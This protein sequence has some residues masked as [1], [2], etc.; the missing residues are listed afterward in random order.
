MAG[1]TSNL[2]LNII[3][4]SD[5]VDPEVINEN[6]KTLDR[7]GV[8][9][10]VESGQSGNWTYRK[11]KSGIVECWTTVEYEATTA[12]GG[13]QSMIQLPFQFATP[14]TATVSGGLE[15]RNDG[16][17]QYV[18]TSTTGINVWMNKTSSQSLKRWFYCHVYG[19]VN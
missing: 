8:D 18:K 9:Y 19:K 2:N 1:S 11:Y 15:G 5:Y 17:V 16:Y 13:L 12:T 7:L 3:D 4:P 10:I 6:T 14:P